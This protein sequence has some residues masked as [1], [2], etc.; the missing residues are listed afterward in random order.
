MY[1]SFEERIDMSE[2]REGFRPEKGLKLAQR[3]ALHIEKDVIAAG[4]RVGT[5]LGQEAELLTRYPVSRPILREAI[6]ILEQDGIAQMAR[7]PNGGLTVIAPAEDTVVLA[8][9]NYLEASRVEATEILE[10]RKLLESTMLKLAAQKLTIES[11]QALR[12]LDAKV[13]QLDKPPLALARQLLTAIAKIS[14]NPALA[15]F[16]AALAQLG[17]SLTYYKAFDERE[18]QRYLEAILGLRHEQVEALIGNDTLRLFR[19]LDSEE[20]LL[21]ELHS[22]IAQSGKRAKPMTREHSEKITS[23]LMDMGEIRRK[24]KL[25]D[26]VSMQLQMMIIQM[27]WPEGEKLSSEA[28]L[29]EQLGVSRAVLREAIRGLE[30][31]G[32]VRA[33]SGRRGGLYVAVPDPRHTIRSVLLYLNHMKINKAHIYELQEEFEPAAV[34]MLTIA[35]RKHGPQ[36][37]K[38]LRDVIASVE[39]Q[40]GTVNT[41]EYMTDFYETLIDCCPNRIL[42]FFLKVFLLAVRNVRISPKQIAAARLPEYVNIHTQLVD[43]I[44]AN[45]EG[46]ARRWMIELRRQL[47]ID[48][49]HD[50]QRTDLIEG[51]LAR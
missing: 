23:R 17:V 16:V 29:Q 34:T 11:L 10:A 41:R 1:D 50:Q 18:I 24:V 13:R 35:T 51:G 48:S 6:A 44:E 46:L 45:E 5:S 15:T 3:L 43:A 22:K 20:H 31:L 14:G 27:G 8:I 21:F 38:P 28:Q 42:S 19:T 40:A 39:K 49:P 12:E 32:V 2:N 9:R 47:L 33:E 7:G 36:T 37:L 26:V 4:W 30:R 25:A